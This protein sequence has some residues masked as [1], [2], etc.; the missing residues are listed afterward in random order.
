MPFQNRYFV[1]FYECSS[2]F[3]AMAWRKIMHKDISLLWNATHSVSL[4]F[5]VITFDAIKCIQ[6][7]VKL[8]A[9]VQVWGAISSKGPSPQRKVNVNMDSAKYQSDI[10]HY[11]DMTCKCVVLLKKGYISCMISCHAIT[12][13]VLEHS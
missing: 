4:D 10:I 1:T 11:I 2:T 13:K 7:T 3:R 12:L 5:T 6:T 8:P 9:S